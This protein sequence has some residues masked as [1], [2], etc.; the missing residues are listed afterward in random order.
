MDADDL[1]INNS[2]VDI[3]LGSD[4]F[5]NSA[6]TSNNSLADTNHLVDTI[7]YR[8]TFNLVAGTQQSISYPP[9]HLPPLPSSVTVYD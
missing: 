1:A 7:R 3:L 8:L 6:T 4:S 9:T 5:A 2:L